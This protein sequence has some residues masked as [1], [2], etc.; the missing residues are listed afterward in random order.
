MREY[1]NLNIKKIYLNM[2]TKFN[3]DECGRED[4]PISELCTLQ[5]I[6]TKKGVNEG[7]IIKQLCEDCYNNKKLNL[8]IS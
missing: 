7:I 6:I 5:I 8:N 4:I 1:K 2:I 3:C